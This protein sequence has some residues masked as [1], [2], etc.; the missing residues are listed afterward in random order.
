M[1]YRN[2]H[3]QVLCFAHRLEASRFFDLENFQSLN[4]HTYKGQSSYIL[5][6]GE[7]MQA[8][9]ESLT[10]FL[11]TQKDVTKVL[12]FGVA[13][14][15]PALTKIGN[16]YPI[17]SF[18]RQ[19]AS[20][21]MEFTS[22]TS[23]T[24]STLDLVSVENR[25]YD[26]EKA[27]K[28]FLFAPIIDREAWA[29]ASVCKRF[30]KD[31]YAFKYISD[32]ATREACSQIK[33]IAEQISEVLVTSYK[34]LKLK[35]IVEDIDILNPA[36]YHFTFTQKA[37]WKRLLQKISLKERVS[38]NE[39]ISSIPPM[40]ALKPKDRT[41]LVLSYLQERLDP[42][43]FSIRKSIEDRLASFNKKDIKVNYDRT[44]E[45]DN[46]DIYFQVKNTKDL[47]DKLSML[48]E[49]PLENITKLLRG[50]NVD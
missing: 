22:F 11:A 30:K 46:L 47:Q 16:V 42:F 27:Q 8:A 29:L 19:K 36:G 9:T 43:T 17:R 21:D 10:E 38:I 41:K 33:E 34:E 45:T 4:D 18:Y 31:F 50:E 12:N 23:S 25:I 15:N 5:L 40:Q 28:L 14:G 13:A 3:M 6:T 20:E 2:D 35:T 44:L 48:S 26:A 49:L 39:V 24:Q 7:G 32:D 37:E 1:S